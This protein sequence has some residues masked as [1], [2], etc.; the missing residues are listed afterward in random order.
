M[1]VDE[2]AQE[3]RRVDGDSENRLGAGALAEALMP[4]IVASTALALVDRVE[5]LEKALR[6]ARDTFKVGYAAD[7]TPAGVSYGSEVLRPLIVM[8][9]AAL[10]LNEETK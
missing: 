5:R 2:L 4:F 7:G 10:N 6:A 8:L 3:I 9:D 1:N